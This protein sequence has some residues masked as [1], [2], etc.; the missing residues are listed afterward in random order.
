MVEY[1]PELEFRLEDNNNFIAY[2]Y[3]NSEWLDDELR[4]LWRD[5]KHLTQTN[6][7]KVRRNDLCP[8]NSGKKYKKCCGR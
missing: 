5:R 1:C 3:H 2:L 7:L 4:I 8:C 6:R